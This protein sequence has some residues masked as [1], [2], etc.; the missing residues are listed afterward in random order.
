M[1]GKTHTFFLEGKW[2][3]KCQIL[4][5]VLIVVFPR[6]FQTDQS[7]LEFLFMFMIV[8]ENLTG[9]FS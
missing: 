9:N 3:S 1:M 4:I 6:K 5:Y 7:P 2:I 8:T